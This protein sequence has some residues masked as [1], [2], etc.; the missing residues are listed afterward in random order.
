M[1]LEKILQAVAKYKTC[2]YSCAI[3]DNEFAQKHIDKIRNMDNLNEQYEYLKGVF[4]ELEREF[5]SKEE[6]EN[7]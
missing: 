7:D 5:G 1:T 4:D 6:I 3:E 2:L